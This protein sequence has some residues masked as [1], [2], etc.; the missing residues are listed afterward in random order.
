MNNKI[1]RDAMFR[2]NVKYWQLSD[3][4]LKISEPTLYRKLR[5]EIPVEEQKE[6][7][8]LIEEYAKKGGNDHV[9]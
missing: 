3:D 2:N 9:E 7:A 4:I 8:K 1:I 5:H 6:I